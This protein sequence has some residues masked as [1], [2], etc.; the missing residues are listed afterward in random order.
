MQ[1]LIPNIFLLSLEQISQT[2]SVLQIQKS[3]Q[4]SQTE[5]L[6]L[7]CL[8]GTL[9]ESSYMQPAEGTV[10]SE[11]LIALGAGSSQQSQNNPHAQSCGRVAGQR[12]RCNL[13]QQKLTGRFGHA[14]N[15]RVTIQEVHQVLAGLSLLVQFIPLGTVGLDH[16]NHRLEFRIQFYQCLKRT[17]SNTTRF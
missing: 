13:E 3:T 14:A 9:S 11:P 1:H 2:S 12:L 16:V 7:S 15:T 8:E 6:S 4:H 10:R 17:E 5:M